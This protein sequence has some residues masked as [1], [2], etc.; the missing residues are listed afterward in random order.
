MTMWI[1][2]VLL[3][4]VTLGLPAASRVTWIK[5]PANQEVLPG[6]SVVLTCEVQGDFSSIR[7]LG[8]TRTHETDLIF[9][10]PKGGVATGFYSGFQIVNVFDLKIEVY[11]IHAGLSEYVAT[12][13]FGTF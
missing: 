13:T 5:T 2:H 10:E 8:K 1:Y 11:I 4:T 7:W 6:Q 12:P 3:L 9:L